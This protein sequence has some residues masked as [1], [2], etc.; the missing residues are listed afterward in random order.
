L[1]YYQDAAGYL[2]QAAAILE[3]MPPLAGELYIAANIRTIEATLRAR[4]RGIEDA[5]N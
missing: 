2:A 5:D 4:I 1:P 3:A